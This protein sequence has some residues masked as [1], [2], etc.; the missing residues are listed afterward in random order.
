MVD[1]IKANNYRAK[2]LLEYIA[3][4]QRE[5]RQ[6]ETDVAVGNAYDGFVNRL[7]DHIKQ[8]GG[9][10]DQTS[11]IHF[12]KERLFTVHSGMV[13]RRDKMMKTSN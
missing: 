4:K 8:A 3:E 10:M 13:F 9:K 5:T 1:I 2:S 7:N 6:T 11:Q 12:N